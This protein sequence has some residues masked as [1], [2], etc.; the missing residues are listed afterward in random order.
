MEVKAISAKAEVVDAVVVVEARVDIVEALRELAKKTD[1]K[2]DDSLVE[3]VAL[4]ARNLD[5]K[6]V[7]L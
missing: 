7:A 5:W 4:A 3:M 2:I 1:N 6:G